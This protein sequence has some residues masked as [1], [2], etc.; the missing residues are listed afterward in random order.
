MLPGAHRVGE[1]TF[2]SRGF[3]SHKLPH[4]RLSFHSIS[5]KVTELIQT[6]QASAA[7]LEIDSTIQVVVLQK[8]RINLPL[9]V[10]VN[11]HT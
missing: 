1:C 4:M 11:P 10:S 8:R 3:E 6:E 7:V 2:Y 5:E 9:N